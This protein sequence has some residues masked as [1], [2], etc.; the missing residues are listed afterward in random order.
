MSGIVGGV[1]SKSGSIGKAQ[2]D[3]VIAI[4]Y[5]AP[6]GKGS[7]V[8]E[9]WTME[10]VSGNRKSGTSKFLCNVVIYHGQYS[11]NANTDT[12]NPGF[13]WRHTFNNSSGTATTTDIAGD[14]TSSNWYYSDVP[15]LGRTN[16]IYNGGYD[17]VEKQS[18][19]QIINPP[20]GNAGDPFTIQQRIYA[21]S[22]GIW[23]SRARSGAAHGC[24]SAMI[25]YE[26][27]TNTT[28]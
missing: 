21:G 11:D 9:T 22:G 19:A 20:K 3:S 23:M 14:F 7:V 12:A 2:A 25:C 16:V 6:T 17:S 13:R 26:I 4:H 10:F 15:N 28:I 8:N 1:N 5:A 18:M 27:E 24:H